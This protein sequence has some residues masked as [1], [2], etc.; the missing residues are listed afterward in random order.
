MVCVYG[1]D[2][3]EWKIR[4]IVSMAKYGLDL[5]FNP[6]QMYSVDAR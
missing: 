1:L 5:T 3:Q 6:V 2:V 4:V